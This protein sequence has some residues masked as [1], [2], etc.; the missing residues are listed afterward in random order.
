MDTLKTKLKKMA[1]ILKVM[2]LYFLKT[3]ELIQFSHGGFFSF[4]TQLLLKIPVF[5][6]NNGFVFHRT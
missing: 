2:E 3:N 5:E 6:F 1:K 4:S